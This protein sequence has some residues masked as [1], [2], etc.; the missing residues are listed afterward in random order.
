MGSIHI[1][2]I[3]ATQIASVGIDLGKT[4]FTWLHQGRTEQGSGSQEVL[5]CAAANVYR[6]PARIADRASE[7]C[8][9][10]HFLGSALRAQGPF[11]L[12]TDGRP[13]EK[14]W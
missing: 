11:D 9:G 14:R 5:T 2:S 4:T 12:R 7:A 8:A 6:E 10:A 1:R 3:I 13:R